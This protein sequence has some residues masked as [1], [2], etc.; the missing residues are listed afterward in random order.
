MAQLDFDKI[1]RKTSNGNS[2]RGEAQLGFEKIV[3]SSITDCSLSHFF[4][5]FSFLASVFEEL[6]QRFSSAIRVR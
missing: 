2:E 5:S 1:L 6:L 4:F 3:R